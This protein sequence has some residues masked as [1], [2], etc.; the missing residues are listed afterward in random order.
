[1]RR[2]IQVKCCIVFSIMHL[3][4][5]QRRQRQ[6]QDGLFMLHN[7]GRVHSLP[8]T[9]GITDFQI[10]FIADRP[11]K[12][13]VVVTMAADDLKVVT[14][15]SP[16]RIVSTFIETFEALSTTG[17]LLIIIQNTGS[18]T[19][20]YNVSCLLGLYCLVTWC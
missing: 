14:K 10:N 20:T 2:Y 7:F 16:G 1:M 19:A 5:L 15:E 3:P 9:R 12:S 18:F 13:I 17:L 6:K 8:H 4:S 11:T